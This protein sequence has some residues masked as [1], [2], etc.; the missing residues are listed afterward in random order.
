MPSKQYTSGETNR[1]GKISK[2]GNAS[3]R[4]H[5]RHGARTV[6]NWCNKKDD[7]LSLWLQQLNQRMHG[8]KAVVA[9]ATKLARIIWSVLFNRQAFDISKACV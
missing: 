6:L 5:L 8:C 4:K 3:L 7:T 9:L 1:L 2:R